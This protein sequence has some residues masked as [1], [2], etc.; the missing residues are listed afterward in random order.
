MTVCT[1][2]MKTRVAITIDTEPSV[3]GAFAEP[4]RYKPLLHEPVWGAVNGKSEALGFAVETL[5]SH[6][7]CGSFFVETVHLTYFPAAEMGGYVRWLHAAGQDIQLHLHPVWSRFDGARYAA[8]NDRCADLPEERLAELIVEG[9][10]RIRDWCGTEPVSLRTGNFSASTSVY[11]AMR[12]AGLHLA[13]N[14]CVAVAP[15]KEAALRL[16]GGARRIEGVTE[17]PVTCFRE[18]GIVGRGRF[19]PLQVSACSFGEMRALLRALNAAGGAVA[20]IVTHP[21]EFLRWSGP[22]FGRMRPN[23]TVQRRFQDLCRFLAEETEHFEVVPLRRLAAEGVAIEE[24]VT[25]D[26]GPLL[27]TLRAAENFM[28]DHLPYVPRMRK[29]QDAG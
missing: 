3:A 24:A 13:S 4:S 12:R 27:G 9:A 17:L 20:I 10:A 26:G 28:S 22:Q 5:Q 11:R 23:S 7:L 14:V 2:P 19:R 29:R 16:A 8:Q 15:P 25:L 21:F 1:I 18:H 6:G